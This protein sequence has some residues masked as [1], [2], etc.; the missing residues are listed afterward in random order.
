MQRLMPKSKRFGPSGNWGHALSNQKEDDLAV[1]AFGLQVEAMVFGFSKQFSD[2]GVA[3]L[4][5]IP[6]I[7]ELDLSNTLVTNKGLSYLSGM[8]QLTKLR[9][10]STKIT[11]AGLRNLSGLTELRELWLINTKITDAGLKN[12]KSL[13]ALEE[14]A[15]DDTLVTDAGV[16]ELQQSL[17]NC[18]IGR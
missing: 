12:L 1:V 18:G 15:L 4:K 9:L 11:D 5:G 16:N 13:C 6:E 14:L 8:T 10:C 17:P 7:G 2:N 3:Q